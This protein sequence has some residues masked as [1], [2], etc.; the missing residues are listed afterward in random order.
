M[1]IGLAA[2]GAQAG[3]LAV[4]ELR[5]GPAA[6]QL[7]ST[8]AHSYFPAVAK[9][10][11]GAVAMVL[12]GALLLVGVVRLLSEGPLVRHHAGP[13]FLRLLAAL[14]TIQLGLFIA[15]EVVEA[16]VAGLPARSAAQLLL[17]GILGQL[18]VAVL[19]ATVLRWLWSRVETVVEELI[20]IT[21]VGIVPPSLTP[22][23]A[24][25]AIDSDRAVVLRHRERSAF[26]RRGPP[27][28]FSTRT[29]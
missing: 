20:S 11:L 12:I 27:A 19:A 29:F 24:I 13:S 22:I 2:A 18:P 21:R 7:Q 28:S 4:Y 23:A 3:H 14:F 10:S 16:A 15:Q 26:A 17:W 9:T 25:A 8:G 5:F 1:L 6:Q